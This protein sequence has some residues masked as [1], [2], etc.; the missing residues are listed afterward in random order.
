M[1]R[2][3]LGSPGAA[4]LEVASTVPDFRPTSQSPIRAYSRRHRWFRRAM[5]FQVFCGNPRAFGRT[6]AESGHEWNS[7]PSL[8]YGEH[9]SARNRRQ[10]GLLRDATNRHV[11][12]GKGLSIG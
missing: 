10:T 1:A 2:R 4:A 12:L 7:A 11:D 8:N 5:M 9:A 6:F 3:A